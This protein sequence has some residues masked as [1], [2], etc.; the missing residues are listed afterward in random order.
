M[1]D[2]L[3]NTPVKS[4]CTDPGCWN[5]NGTTHTF[6]FDGGQCDFE[7]TNNQLAGSCGAFGY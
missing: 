4:G 7:L 5:L 6:Y 2:T 3:L 1:T